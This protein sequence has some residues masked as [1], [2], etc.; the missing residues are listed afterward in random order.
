MQLTVHIACTRG[1]PEIS[2]QSLG[3]YPTRLGDEKRSRDLVFWNA[4]CSS[5]ANSE[6]W[7][8][9]VRRMMGNGTLCNCASFSIGGARKKVFSNVCTLLTLKE[10][11]ISSQ[12]LVT[13]FC[14]T[15]Y[16]SIALYAT[17]YR[18][19]PWTSLIPLSLHRPR[20]PTDL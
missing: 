15:L 14:D 6:A 19:P 3:D 12:A 11:G 17:L 7:Q 18:L 8:Y 13:C 2:G 16:T 9:E 4:F 5:Y 10:N 20:I 1:V